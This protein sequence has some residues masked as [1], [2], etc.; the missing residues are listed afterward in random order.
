[1]LERRQPARSDLIYHTLHSRV[2]EH[3]GFS[4]GDTLGRPNVLD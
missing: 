2:G 1:M 3:I 4:E